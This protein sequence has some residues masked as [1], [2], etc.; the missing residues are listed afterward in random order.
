MNKIIIAILATALIVTGAFALFGKTAVVEKTVGAIA[1]P[2]LYSYFSVYG[3]FTQGGG[4]RATSTSNSAETLLASDIDTENVVDYTANVSS[5]TLT[6]PASSTMTG[7]VPKAGLTRTIFIR[8]ATTTAAINLTLAGGTGT[9]L[10]QATSSNQ[11]GAKTIYGDTDGDN[12]AR[13]DLI[14][15]AN[16]DIDVLMTVFRD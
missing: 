16:T 5:V 2:D 1:G 10:K 12:Y 13:L 14:R 4:V 15:K 3:V 9:I 6:L 11:A 7:L 8:N